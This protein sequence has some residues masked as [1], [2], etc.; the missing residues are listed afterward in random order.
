MVDRYRYINPSRVRTLV[1]P[2]NGC[3]QADFARYLELVRSNANEV[4]LLDVTPIAQLQYFNPQTFPHGKVMFDYVSHAPEADS[5]FLHDFEPFRKTFI[6]LGVGKYDEGVTSKEKQTEV[7][8]SLKKWHPSSIVHNVIYFDTPGDVIDDLNPS[9]DHS[10]KEVFYHEGSLQHNITALETLMCEVTRNFLTALDSYASSYLNIT[11]RSPVSISDSHNLTKTISKAQKRISSSSGSFK[12]SFSSTSS[13]NGATSASDLKSKSQQRH[14][15]RRSKLLGSFY[16]LAGKY[17]DALEY[18]T[19]SIANLKKCDDYLWLGSALEGIGNSVVMLHFLG[20]SYNLSSSTIISVLQISKSK[21]NAIASAVSATSVESSSPKRISTDS[22]SHN[23]TTNGHL[24]VPHQTNS[25]RNSSSS[26]INFNFATS[27]IPGSGPDLN[28]LPIPQ[29][30]KLISSKALQYYQLSTSDYENTVPDLVYVES[31]LRLIKFMI[32]IYLGGNELNS[33][34][35]ESIVKS[36]PISNKLSIYSSKDD[37]SWF[38]KRDIL[39]EIDKVFSLQLVDMGLIDQCRIYCCLATM[40]S[41]LELFRKRAFILRILLVSLLPK[42]ELAAKEKENKI[43][44]DTQ[45][46]ISI[47]SFEGTSSNGSQV[48]SIRQIYESLFEIYKINEETE[49]SLDS[50]SH[51]AQ[52]NWAS[53][54]LSLLKLCLKIS[55]TIKDYPFLMK[56]C[57]LLLTRYSHCLPVDDQCKLKE[58]I[59]WLSYMSHKNNSNIVAPYWD[60]FLVRK[61]K[62]ISNR[63]KDELIPFAEYQKT[64]NNVGL[65]DG[66][67][68]RNISGPSGANQPFVFNPFNKANNTAINKDKLL[69]KDEIYQLKVSLQN[70][71]SFEI[72]LNDLSIVT[73]GTIAVQTLK[74]LVKSTSNNNAY[75]A[76]SHNLNSYNRSRPNSINN[77]MRSAPHITANQKRSQSALFNNNQGQQEIS[78]SLN[79]FNGTNST[80]TIG[81]KSVEHLLVAFKPLESGELN[82]KGFE[83]SLS[84]CQPQFFHIIDKEIYKGLLKVKKFSNIN[85]NDHETGDNIIE[86]LIENKVES[87]AITKILTLT[88]VPPQPNLSLTSILLTNGWLMLLEGEKYKFS[89]SLS[90]QSNE[91]INYLSFSFWDSTIEPLNKKLNSIGVNNNQNMSASDIHEIEWLLLKFK[92]FKILN[93]DEISSFYKTIEP[94]GDIKIDYEMTGKRGMNELKI[95]LEY[96]NKQSNDALKSFV[97]H[98]HVPLCL[99]VVP[100]FDMVGFDLLPLLSSSL[101][102]LED[103]ELMVQ[104]GD[105]VQRNLEAVLKFITDV[106]EK[107]SEKVSDYCL[108]VIDLRNSWNEKLQSNLT[109]QVNSKDKFSVKEDISSGKT[110][111]F[112]LPIKRISSKEADLTRL[113]PSLRNKQYIKNYL[114]SE[115]EDM[116]MRELFWLR[117][118][119]LEK[120]TGTWETIPNKSTRRR[121]GTIELRSL[122]LTPKMANVLIYSKIQ[123][124]HQLFNE[125]EPDISIKRNGSQFRLQTEEFYT[126]RTTICNDTDTSITGMLR[127]L[128]YPL[129]WPVP[130]SSIVNSL[131][132]NFAKNQM[133]IDRRIL[134][135]GILQTSIGDDSMRPGESRQLDLSFVVLEKGEYEWG[136]VLDIFNKEGLKIVGREPIYISA[137]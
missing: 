103:R 88:V 63:N 55:E 81:P 23:S 73:D 16:L 7:L 66:L 45:R 99:S 77:K 49:S 71:F 104:E 127:H 87:R 114:I 1:V 135:N 58:K 106:S 30:I 25:P 52:S 42:L 121:Y 93:K 34:V 5:I 38:L 125:N 57:T 97:K 35:M 9:S 76:P 85:E 105:I 119:I 8:G 65:V 36:I 108:L 43:D 47:I 32:C 80:I 33:T 67:P 41:D 113:I 70:P 120:L 3:T 96:A 56:L 53:L 31:L 102:G 90:N 64:S 78:P 129:A 40:Y 91:L 112:L 39:K 86:N 100:S 68:S 74:S 89:I 17:S 11:L 94:R 95:I 61:V 19:D 134:I 130:P 128:P 118:S 83:V 110:T 123:M 116:D 75:Q 107:R 126:L 124:H 22:L 15:G 18:F 82:I 51:H 111:R 6:I 26:T 12:V 10:T 21:F 79:V 28:S 109:Y 54:Q 72:E 137:S 132:T 92:P 133:T 84:N 48:S 60:P 62:F 4:R 37:K 2:I 98:V 122:K 131:T 27:N 117:E 14:N 46:N 101:Q 50:A 115:E 136:S 20:I 13:T 69:I 44:F 59:E 29:L 24:S